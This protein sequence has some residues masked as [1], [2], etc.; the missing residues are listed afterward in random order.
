VNISV[1]RPMTV[2]CDCGELLEFYELPLR[3]FA[4]LVNENKVQL[5]YG[6]DHSRS[7]SVVIEWVGLKAKASR[8][9]FIRR[10]RGAGKC[11]ADLR[12]YRVIAYLFIYHP[13]INHLSLIS[14]AA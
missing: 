11:G 8:L 7:P 14:S 5:Q 10:G 3:F 13:H 6:N 1:E 9:C 4:R 12:G 2:Q